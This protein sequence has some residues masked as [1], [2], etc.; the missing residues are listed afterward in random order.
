MLA[1]SAKSSHI[2]WALVGVST[3]IVV[4][5]LYLTPPGIALQQAL[6]QAFAVLA[7]HMLGYCGV[8]IMMFGNQLVAPSAT[9]YVENVVFPFLVALSLTLIWPMKLKA[10]LI[11]LPCAF[12][13]AGVLQLFR[14]VSCLLLAAHNLSFGIF[15][16][17]W[18]WPIL[19]GIIIAYGG[20]RL[21]LKDRPSSVVQSV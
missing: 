5:L 6:N 1:N 18:V 9:I 11:T 3:G 4:L 7:Y 14:A 13:L 2:G 15:A 20:V 12:V 10:R 17:K 19:F 16:Y 8:P 21:W